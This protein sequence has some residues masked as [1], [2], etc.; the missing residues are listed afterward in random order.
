MTTFT[1]SKSVSAS[2]LG[3]GMLLAS[4]PAQALDLTTWTSTGDVSAATNQSTITNAFLGDDGAINFN[5]SPNTPVSTNALENFL[6]LAPGALGTTP[7]EGSAIKQTFT[8]QA[9]DQISFNW[10]FFT[11]E[12]TGGFPDYAFVTVNSA[13]NTLATIA[14]ATTPSSPFAFQTGVNAFSYTFNTAGTYTIGI[15]VVD[16]T[17]VATSSALQ[18]GNASSTATVVPTPALLPGLIGFGVAALRKRKQNA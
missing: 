12:V 4:A 5:V 7:Q 11:N 8:A 9:G 16:D 13:I 6:G 10:N 15:G 1:V 18:I 2:L 3:L 17:D 14:N